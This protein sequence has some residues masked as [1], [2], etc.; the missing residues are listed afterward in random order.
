MNENI[1]V[2]DAFYNG[3][4][5]FRE[6][7]KAL[8]PFFVKLSV[9]GAGSQS[10]RA[11]IQSQS[12]SRGAGKSVLSCRKHQK[13]QTESPGSPGKVGL[14]HVEVAE[15]ADKIAW[16]PGESRPKPCRSIRKGRQNRREVRE[17]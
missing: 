2:F 4:R 11:E 10:F 16:N 9:R 8:N 14:N 12:R 15:R 13:G 1:R 6:N 3:F 5:A 17:R 7:L